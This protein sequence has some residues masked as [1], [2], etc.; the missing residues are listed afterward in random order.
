VASR[1]GSCGHARRRLTPPLCATG[2]MAAPQP[3][4]RCSRRGEGG[5]RRQ[6]AHCL[7]PL[8]REHAPFVALVLLA[9]PPPGTDAPACPRL[10]GGLPSAPAASP[11]H[12]T[13]PSTAHTRTA[14]LPKASAWGSVRPAACSTFAS[15]SSDRPAHP[16]SVI[17][18][19][20]RCARSL[21]DIGM[22][23]QLACVSSAPSARDGGGA[24]TPRCPR[25]VVG[26]PR[27]RV[28]GQTPADRVRCHHH[29]PLS[30]LLL[31]AVHPVTLY[32]PSQAPSHCKQEELSA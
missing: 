3:S 22:E 25:C 8:S 16:P 5:Q 27:R 10:V 4:R 26:V 18:S 21:A 2:R 7:Q 31:S 9:T 1:C 6:A 29:A 28:G 32:T 15:S 23:R 13:R 12:H 24:R 14:G 20:R 30:T 11:A 19:R 17:V